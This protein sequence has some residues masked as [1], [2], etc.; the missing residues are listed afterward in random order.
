[1][2]EKSM[3]LLTFFG[4]DFDAIE[5]MGVSKIYTISKR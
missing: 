4:T 2:L 5:R 3:K 1:M